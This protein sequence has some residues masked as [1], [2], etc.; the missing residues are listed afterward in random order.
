[1]N[2]MGEKQVMPTM[3]T[4]N[5]AILISLSL[6]M[7]GCMGGKDSILPQDGATMKQVYEGHF[8]GEPPAYKNELDQEGS[9]EKENEL[10]VSKADAKKSEGLIARRH[11]GS[12]NDLTGYTRTAHNEIQQIFPRLKNKTLIM[13][14]FPHLSKSERH[15]VPGYSTAFTMYRQTE[16]ALPGEVSEGY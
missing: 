14:I 5:I 1:M 2:K 8:S 13:Y 12:D 10:A 6:L 3:K 16:Y 15:P 4:Q 7:S 9:G 11:D